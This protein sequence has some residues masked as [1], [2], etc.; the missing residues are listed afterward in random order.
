MNKEV[1]SSAYMVRVLSAFFVAVAVAGGCATAR[2]VS[3]A[4]SPAIEINDYGAVKVMGKPTEVGRVGRAVT[5]AGFRRD[6]EIHVLIP[7]QPD[8]RAMAAVAGELR[9]GGFTRIVFVSS[10]KTAS[11]LAP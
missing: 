3:D 6:E 11:L 9:R 4:E 7:R 1:F 10:R 5:S 2:V 8:R